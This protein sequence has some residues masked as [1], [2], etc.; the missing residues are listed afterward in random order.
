MYFPVAN[1]LL[2]DLVGKELRVRAFGCQ[3]LAA[4]LGFALGEMISLPISNSYMA[5]LAPDEMRGRFM[6][7]LG[8]SW[9][10][11][12]MVGPSLG[13]FLYKS[14]PSLLWIICLV[15][16]LGAALVMKGAEAKE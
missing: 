4:N 11:A 12:M 8:V 1:A 3:R 2:T 15:L 7:L 10:T 16:G 13:I 6:G 9:S 5:E 14:S